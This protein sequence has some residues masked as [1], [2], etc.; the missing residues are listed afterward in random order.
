MCRV[1]VTA[2][3]GELAAVVTTRGRRLLGCVVAL[4]ITAKRSTI[5][6]K[7]TPSFLIYRGG[8][9]R[10]QKLKIPPPQPHL[11][12]T[13]GY[14]RFLLSKPVGGQN[15]ALHAAPAARASNYLVSSAAFPIRGIHLHFHLT[16]PNLKSE[17]HYV[18]IISVDHNVTLW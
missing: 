18:L 2:D 7:S 17:R 11:V 16:S 1:A 8:V 6:C 15:I 14:Q 3:L 12:G 5:A 10:T 9:P 13:E 4:H